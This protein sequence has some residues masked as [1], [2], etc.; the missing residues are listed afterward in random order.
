MEEDRLIVSNGTVC[1]KFYEVLDAI[2]IYPETVQK[3]LDDVQIMTANDVNENSSAEEGMLFSALKSFS[4][5]EPGVGPD[6]LPTNNIFDIPMLLKKSTPPD[7]YHEATVIE[8]LRVE[9]EEIKK[10]LSNFY[11]AKE[12]PDVLGKMILE[13]FD[14]HL[15]SIALESQRHPGIYRESLFNKT[16]DTI[17][18]ALIDLG[19]RK[20][21][22]EI[23]VKVSEFKK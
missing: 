15:A 3:I 14:R 9:I 11:T 5:N 17:T 22:R 12:L 6:N 1:D 23:Q 2:S 8:F 7:L 18:N 19:L 21:S 13:Q 20:S 10:Y 16:C 4:I